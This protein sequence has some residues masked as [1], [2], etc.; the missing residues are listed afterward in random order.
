[1]GS[2][3][4]L[5]SPYVLVAY[6]KTRENTQMSR[7]S[8]TLPNQTKVGSVLRSAGPLLAGELAERLVEKGHA[9]SE[10][11]ARKLI[12]RSRERGEIC[13]T[14]PVT[15]NRSFMCYLDE[16]RGTRYVGAILSVLKHRPPLERLFKVTL[17][18]NG[19]ITAGQIA[20]SACCSDGGDMTRSR[21]L[22]LTSVT[23]Q[24]MTIE[25]LEEVH[26]RSDLF[27]INPRF[28][29]PAISRNSFL[30][31]LELEDVLLEPLCTWLQHCYLLPPEARNVRSS[32]SS[33]TAFN[34]NWWDI[35]G[36]IYVGHE[37]IATST[38]S[39]NNNFLVA[40]FVSYRQATI[41]DAEAFIARV[42][43]V[44]RRW[45]SLKLHPLFI[46]SRFSEKA[47][48][49]LRKNG[50]A[51]IPA[52]DVFGK[53]LSELL[54]LFEEALESKNAEDLSVAKISDL[55][56][57]SKEAPLEDG[58]I[59]NLRGAIFEL[60]VAMYYR[61]LGYDITLQKFVRKPD[62]QLEF[63]IDVVAVKADK[64]A[65]LAECKGRSSGT[66]EDSDEIK[67]HFG[68]RLSAATDPFGWNVTDLY[69]RVDA[70]FITLGNVDESVRPPMPKSGLR[71]R[72][73]NRIVYD[74]GEFIALLD[75]A[76]EKDLKN[77]VERFF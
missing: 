55:L 16:H 50:T 76:G 5:L 32:F 33:A 28:G 77:L 15:F 10:P 37:S 69:D 60:I 64:Q 62:E 67:R 38:S 21:R 23:D 75:E 61:N 53:H 47:W 8:P 66:V 24:A 65:I 70:V 59:G 6:E 2:E 39:K 9:S 74:R 44:R 31:R 7:S 49:V 12:Q 14:S 3:G 51:A 27:Q 30:K 48:R 54:R 17:A 46:A 73:I 45:K 35:N 1:M 71:P 22:S 43:D 13:S 72:G 4:I 56:E 29:V 11:N 52:S 26:G 58:L 19:F 42:S 20:K 40:D 68:K 18:N 36:P 57:L 41:A 25:L 34:Q 63:E